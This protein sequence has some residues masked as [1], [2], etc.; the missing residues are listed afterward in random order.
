MK[1]THFFWLKILTLFYQAVPSESDGIKCY[2]GVQTGKPITKSHPGVAE[3]SCPNVKRCWSMYNEANGQ[4]MVSCAQDNQQHG[5]K[6]KGGVTLVAHR[7]ISST[8][9]KK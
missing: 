9:A 1:F 5:C 4:L 6:E 8:D 2:V 3:L 7:I